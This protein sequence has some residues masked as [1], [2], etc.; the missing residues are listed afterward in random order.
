MKKFI[1]WFN[2]DRELHLPL[3]VFII[4]SILNIIIYGYKILMVLN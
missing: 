2:R 4:A 1:A 3:M